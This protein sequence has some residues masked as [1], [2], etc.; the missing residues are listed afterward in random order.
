MTPSQTFDMDSL[1]HIRLAS[2]RQTNQ[3][4]WHLIATTS[5]CAVA[6]LGIL[7]LSL[8]TYLCNMAARCF[9]SSAVPEPS[10]SEQDPSS[11]PPEPR[12][13]EYTPNNDDSQRCRL[14]ILLA[15]IHKLMPDYASFL[16]YLRH[17]PHKQ[18]RFKVFYTVSN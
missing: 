6:V 2:T 16:H 8:H 10:T 18:T 1:F 13:R 7:Y 4:Y 5:V 3:T 14:H 15:T 12:R 11:L 17:T 9:S